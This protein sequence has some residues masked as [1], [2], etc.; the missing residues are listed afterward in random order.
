MKVR[1]DVVNL[2]T[3][4]IPLQAYYKGYFPEWNMDWHTKVRCPFH[5]DNTPSFQ[6]YDDGHYHCY[7][8]NAHGPGPIHFEKSIKG[9]EFHVSLRR[10]YSEWYE[11]LVDLEVLQMQ[12]LNWETHL[13]LVEQL[14][15]ERGWSR[16]IMDRL[17]LGFTMD[18]PRLAVPVTN[19]H[20]YTNCVIYYDVFNKLAK[21]MK[22]RPMDGFG[23]NMR[24]LWPVGLLSGH[25]AVILCEGLGDV[26]TAWTYDLPAMTLGACTYD[27]QSV[28]VR[29]LE[30]K[31]VTICYDVDEPGR[32]GAKKMA[33][34]LARSGMPTSIKNVVLPLED[35]EHTDLSDFLFHEKHTAEQMRTII[36]AADFYKPSVPKTIAVKE[37]LDGADRGTFVSSSC[38]EFVPLQDILQADQFGKPFRTEA[39]AVGRAPFPMYAPKV[40]EVRCKTASAKCKKQ[41]TCP[42]SGGESFSVKI[43][44]DH[45]RILDFLESKKRARVACLKEVLEVLPGCVLTYQMTEAYTVYKIMLAM[46]VGF[47]STEANPETL[48][49][50]GYYFGNNLRT[51]IPYLFTGRMRMVPETTVAAAVLTEANALNTTMDN[52]SVDPEML[53]SLVEFRVRE[54]NKIYEHLLEYYDHCSRSIT[55]IVGRN[56]IHMACDLVFF[57]PIS[58]Y[59]SEEFLRRAPLD[60][61]VFGDPRTGKNYI[62]DGFQRYYEHGEVISGECVS[63]MNLIGGIRS[64][65]GFEGLQWGRFVARHKDTVIV[66]EMGEID[67][68]DLGLLSRIRSEGI[69]NVDKLGLHQKADA[70]CGVLWLSNPRDGRMLGEYAYGVKALKKLMPGAADI[71]RFDYVAAVASGEVDSEDINRPGKIR[72]KHRFS[73]QQCHNLILWIKSRKPEQISFSSECVNYIFEQAKDFGQTYW[74][75]IP[76][77][78]AEN[79][80]FKLAKVSCA[81]AARVFS[82]DTSGEKLQVNR[83]HARVAVQFLHALYDNDTLGFKLY[84]DMMKDFSNIEETALEQKMKRYAEIA[85]TAYYK[86]CGMLIQ[87][88]DGMTLDDMQGITA[89]DRK[90]TAMFRNLLVRHNC[91]VRKGN[92]YFNTHAFNEYLRKVVEKGGK[93]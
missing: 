65:G 7:G 9:E 4:S 10:L 39:V 89:L 50:L 64:T 44:P 43:R 60:V 29:L 25:E 54:G 46:P 81:I 5:K 14:E 22:I 91:L 18:G 24:R 13:E 19:H 88:G 53:E 31:D 20:G 82:S 62:A 15:R 61:L 76:L 73:K 16:K 83:A 74:S 27:M 90:E 75:K 30:G 6:L 57:S 41:G 69:A 12:R 11:K 40:L 28:D 66:D 78:L 23:P 68:K 56:L 85:D 42:L 45:P 35:E 34:R 86:F 52:F 1:D 71:A 32:I 47:E 3:Q 36:G 72:E 79:M 70:I 93:K 2:V 77:A 49:V 63:A 55:G 8:C 48:Q 92:L 33:D 38:P 26:I 51:N 58:F 37:T 67:P 80:R 87:G 59:F 17:S 21:D 84:S